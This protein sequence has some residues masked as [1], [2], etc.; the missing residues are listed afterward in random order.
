M[1]ETYYPPRARWYSSLWRFWYPLKRRLYLDRL[2]KFAGEPLEWSLLGLVLPGWAFVWTGQRILGVVL[3]AAHCLS[4]VVFIVWVGYPV[5]NF[6]LTAMISIHAGSIL[7]IQEH[8]GFW[9]RIVFS[10][11]T[12]LGMAGFVYMPLR[13]WL[14]RN[15]LMPLTMDGRVIVIRTGQPKG[16]MVR[17]D[18]IAYRLR[19]YSNYEVFARES[20]TLG[21]VIAVAGDEVS[22]YPLAISVNGKSYP[23]RA[24]MPTNGT[25]QVQQHYWFI[26]PE[27]KVV[28]GEGGRAEDA[29]MQLAI[30][31]ETSY[32]GVP[33]RRWFW[34]EQTVP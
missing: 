16:V 18:T 20:C 33:Y 29:M 13:G 11:V 32:V 17:G 4:A 25:I 34:R 28:G 12:F 6:A 14:E 10:L 5:S 31:P 1:T 30:V 23:R 7:R 9:K 21:R 15:W 26:W 2:P 27:V 22:F 8:I 3:G 24:Y 19:R